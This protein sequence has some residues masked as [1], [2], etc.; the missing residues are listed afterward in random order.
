M[1]ENKLTVRLV[2]DKGKVRSY[3]HESVA[4]PVLLDPDPVLLDPDPEGRGDPKGQAQQEI[5]NW[6]HYYNTDRP[7]S[8][9]CDKTPMEVYIENM[10]A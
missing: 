1:P 10:A 5:E 7:H 9:L 6:L 2:S 8:S 3:L 4:D